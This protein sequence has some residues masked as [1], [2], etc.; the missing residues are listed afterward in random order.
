[1]YTICVRHWT[2]LS[3]E[4]LSMNRAQIPP[5]DEKILQ[6]PDHELPRRVR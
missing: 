3:T 4:S 2:V 5:A 6:F 1:V